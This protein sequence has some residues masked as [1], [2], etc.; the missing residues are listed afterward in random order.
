M[1]QITNEFREKVAQ[2]LLEQRKN[3]DGSDTAFSRKFGINSAVYS[4]LKN[5]EIEGLLQPAKWISLGRELNVAMN[6]RKWVPVE[7]EVFKLIREDILFCKAFSKS[8][9][10]VDNCGIGKTFTAKY[11]AKTEKNIFYIDC[12]Q[13]RKKNAF[14]RTLAKVVGV[15]TKGR[16]DDIKEETKYFLS[17]LP[18]PVVILDEA[19]ALDKDA[20]G[21]VQEYWNATEGQTGWYMMGANA[22]RSKL[23]KGVEKDRDYF[24][25]LFSRFSEK[26]GSI[27]PKERHEKTDFYRQLITDVLSANMEDKT[28]LKELVNRCLVS[29]NGTITGLRRAE[30]LLILHNQ[31]VA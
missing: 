29:E 21:L 2:A 24:A 5:G 18:A 8:M 11:L 6:A 23:S 27:V 30:S 19:G 7:T 31:E 10:F 25:E 17:I 20:L 12:T 4:R 15:E 14:I 1:V 9:I 28:H 22:L 26:F 3:Y 16:Y 13:C